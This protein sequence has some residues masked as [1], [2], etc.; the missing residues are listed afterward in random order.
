MPKVRSIHSII[1]I[2]LI[3]LFFQALAAYTW[4]HSIDTASTASVLSNA[5]NGFSRS[6]SADNRA[7]SDFDIRHAFNAAVSYNIP[8]PFENK[9]LRA[10]LGGWSVDTI[11]IARTASPLTVRTVGLTAPFESVSIRP[12]VVPGVPLYLFGDQYPGGKAINPAAFARPPVGADGRAARQGTASRNA[13]RGFGAYQLDFALR[14]EFSLGERVRLR[15]R[16]EL[17]NI[18]NHPNFGAVDTVLRFARQVPTDPTSPFIP[19]P[20]PTFGQATQMLG[21]SLGQGG[22]GGGFSPLFQIG[23]PR[24]TQLSVK[25]LF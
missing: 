5:T 2:M 18:L 22:L 11:I 13:F 1:I 19:A 24:S 20:S 21:R 7:N 23:G 14:R 12:D 15:F 10:V 17:F 6:R 9:A 16:A 8:A 3:C 25:L 4:A